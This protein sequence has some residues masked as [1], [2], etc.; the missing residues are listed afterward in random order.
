MAH[1]AA[2][3]VLL[4]A[5]LVAV[6]GGGRVAAAAASQPVV[7]SRTS[8]MF[9]GSTSRENVTCELSTAN[10]QTSAILLAAQNGPKSASGES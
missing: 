7:I 6:A 8:V 1:S 5:Q 10:V 2:A 3:T 9:Q 4:L